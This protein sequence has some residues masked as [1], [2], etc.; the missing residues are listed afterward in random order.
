MGEGSEMDD[1]RIVLPTFFQ[2]GP[3]TPDKTRKTSATAHPFVRQHR[4]AHRGCL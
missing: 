4:R 1:K 3:G 2:Q